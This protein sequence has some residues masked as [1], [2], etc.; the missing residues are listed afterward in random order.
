MINLKELVAILQENKIKNVSTYNLSSGDEE[1]FVILS[2]ANK[3]TDSKKVAEIIAEK[4]N[5]TDK[6]EGF[7]KGEWIVFDFDKVTLH[8][9]LPKVRDK[10]NLDKLYKPKKIS[11]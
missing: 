8:I 7:F 4:Y 10:Y 11:I 6:I 2:T 5:Y 1:K 3:T 9:F